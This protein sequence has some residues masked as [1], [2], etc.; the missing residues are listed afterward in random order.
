[1][2]K[3]RN[4]WRY[5]RM[6]PEQQEHRAS[7]HTRCV[8]FGSDLGQRTKDV[9]AVHHDAFAAGGDHATCP[10]H[11]ER[12]GDCPPGGAELTGD[13][14]LRQGRLDLDALRCASTAL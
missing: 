12:P 8:P 14:L 7:W 11:A 9:Q 6:S 1:M 5:I 10:Q 13:V 2:R 3:R 4:Y